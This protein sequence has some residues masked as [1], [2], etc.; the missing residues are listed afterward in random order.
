MTFR[1]VWT[2]VMCC[3]LLSAASAQQAAAP[4]EAPAKPTLTRELELE[5]EVFALTVEN[6]QLRANLAKASNDA[7][8]LEAQLL[9]QQL[10]AR[11]KTLGEKMVRALGGD[12]EKGDTFDWQTKTLVRAPTPPK[13]QEP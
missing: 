4:S 8:A 6:A 10:T 12:P 2:I 13:G 11:Q 1:A 9:T 7:L 3:S 5:L